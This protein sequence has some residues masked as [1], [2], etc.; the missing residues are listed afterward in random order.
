M[1]T[2]LRDTHEI[3]E[4]RDTLACF[5]NKS[6]LVTGCTGLIGSVLVKV[7]IE[8]NKEYDLGIHILGQAR[9]KQKVKDTFGDDLTDI[10]IIYSNDFTFSVP[11]DYIIH[12]A[13]PTTSKYFVEKPVETIDT[14]F[15]STKLMLEM[16]KRYGASFVFLSS[17]EE[18]GVPYDPNEIMT[19]EKIGIIDH[20]STRSS[21][22]EG[23]RMCEC[24]C[25]A[26]TS[27][28]GLRTEIVRLAQTFGAGLPLTDNRVSMQFAKSVIE[29]KDI[30][31]HTEGK[32][33]SNYCYLTDAIIGIL[34]IA[35]KGKTGN[36]YNVCN[37]T[38]TRSIFEIANLV[39][40][41]VANNSI[42]VKK[43]IPRDHDFGYAPD[44]TLRLNSDKLRQLGW[45]PRVDMIEG[46]KRLVDYLKEKM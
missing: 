6:I 43:D 1:T 23:K 8:A 37:D 42:R 5:S 19:E 28:Y 40:S 7:L 46:Y 21:Y 29:N 18:Y 41:K 15:Q 38:E 33:L 35:A 2:F 14:I 44:T 27:E 36:A 39:A 12:T 13:S 32:S 26:Y 9:S 16:A 24:M 3:L 10:S 4:N 20:L 25:M 22:P 34:T 11:C 31:L 17:M 30:I 45:K